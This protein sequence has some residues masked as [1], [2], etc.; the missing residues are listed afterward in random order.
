M[1]LEI[2]N[3]TTSVFGLKGS[4]KTFFTRWLLNQ[5]AEKGS[6]S[7]VVDMTHH[8]FLKMHARVDRYLPEHVQY[9]PESIRE[10]NDFLNKLILSP[11]RKLYKILAIDESN[12]WHPQ[13]RPLPSAS[14]KLNDENRHV[15][16]GVIHIARRPVQL[17]TN[18]VELSDN[19]VIFNLKGVNDIRYLNELSDGLGDLVCK[20]KPYCFVIVDSNRNYFEHQPIEVKT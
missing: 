16:V 11:P 14:A 7:L 13:G 4:G 15:P 1:K 3:K 19:L 18:I 9:T 6:K 5:Y 8:D 17:N 20:L 2:L 12:R 10:A